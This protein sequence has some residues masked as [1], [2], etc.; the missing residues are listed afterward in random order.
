MDNKQYGLDKAKT[1]RKPIETDSYVND[2]CV[3]KELCNFGYSQPIIWNNR[4]R[5]HTSFT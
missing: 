4:R 2:L 3:K 5:R 1:Q